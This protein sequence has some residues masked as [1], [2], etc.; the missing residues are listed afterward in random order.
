LD[1]LQNSCYIVVANNYC[2][3]IINEGEKSYVNAKQLRHP[4]IE[5]LNTDELYVAND[6][7]IGLDKDLMLLY[8]TNAV[9]KTSIIRAIG[10]SI[11]MAQ[12]GL[13][14]PSDEFEFV[15]YKSIYTRILGNDNLFKGLSTFAVEMSELRVILNTADRNSLIL[16]DELCSGTEH[17]SAVSIFVSG[18]EILSSK[19]TSAIFATHLHEII[20]YEEIER[21]DNLTIKHMSVQYDTS[22]DILIYDRQLRD[23]AGTSMYGLEVC[24]SLHLPDNFLEKAYELRRK[25]KKSEMGIL[26]QKTSHFNSKKIMGMCELCKKS[27]G[28][29]VHHLQHQEKADKNNMINNFHKNHPA[30]LLTLCEDCHNNIHKSGKQHKKVKTSNGIEITEM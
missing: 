19:Q 23:G 15:P 16:G 29:E 20:D 22:R 17:D 26:E 18:L 21:L 30:N 5:K 8:G 4:L 28:E 7:Y 1:V 24:K 10:I 9:G 12:S 6:L 2:K 11:I 27:F 14:V 13:Y 3:P 25:Y